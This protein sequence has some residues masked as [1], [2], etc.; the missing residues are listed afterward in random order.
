MER[1]QVFGS[2]DMQFGRLNRFT[3]LEVKRIDEIQTQLHEQEYL[4]CRSADQSQDRDHVQ[5]QVIGITFKT[6]ISYN[7]NS[8]RFHRKELI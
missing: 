6:E 1:E 8:R 5:S 4:I 2:Q 3:E 7:C